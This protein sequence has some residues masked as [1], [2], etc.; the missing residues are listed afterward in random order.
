MAMAYDELLFVTIRDYPDKET[1]FCCHMSK[2]NSWMQL[3]F[4]WLDVESTSFERIISLL[5]KFEIIYFII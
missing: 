3:Y 1:D 2:K 5:G 4:Y